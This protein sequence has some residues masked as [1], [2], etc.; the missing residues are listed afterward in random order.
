MTTRT[1]RSMSVRAYRGS[2]DTRIGSKRG[3]D[4][5][6][7]IVE[8]GL[9]DEFL[10]SLRIAPVRVE[11]HG[12]SEPLNFGDKR[13]QIVVQRRLPACYDYS[14]QPTPARAKKT[15]D[16]FSRN[17]GRVA[18]GIYKLGIMAI[19]ASEIAAAR[20]DDCADLSREIRQ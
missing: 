14:L 4:I 2:R 6:G 10:Q 1:L 15:K 3:F 16:F 20:K 17:F 11:L 19:R 9:P 12:Q 8:E 7:D 13:R 18:R 5:H